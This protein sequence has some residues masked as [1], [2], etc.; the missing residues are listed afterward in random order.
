KKLYEM[1]RIISDTAEY[2]CYLFNHKCL[3]LLS[4]YVKNLS[5][6]FIGEPI[7]TRETFDNGTLEN[8]DKISANHP[9]EKIGKILR[10]N[11]SAMKKLK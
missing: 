10:R 1:N 6:G 4:E 8:L 5:R 3:P 7:R 2:G 9:I 11:M